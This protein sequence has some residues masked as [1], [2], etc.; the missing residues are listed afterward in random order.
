MKYGF[1]PGCAYATAAGYRPSVEAVCRRLEIE[2]TPIPDWN[3]CGATVLFSVDEFKATALAGR[4]FALARQHG[5][6]QIVTGC[7]A[8]YTTLRKAGDLLL[9]NT[10]YRQ[11]VEQRL[12]A[13]SLTDPQPLP[14][15]HLL[16]VLLDDIPAGTWQQVTASHPCQD[17][18]VGGYYGC[19]MT[20]P[21]EP[22]AQAEQPDLLERFLTRIGFKPMDHAAKTLCCG[23][24]HCVPYGNACNP[25]VTRIVRGIHRQGANL[26]AT[27]C[28]LCQFNLDQGQHRTRDLPRLP[29]L[30][31]TQLAGLAMGLPPD[32]LGLDRLLTPAQGALN[33]Q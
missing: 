5:F 10:D 32:T 14:V 19:Q 16:Q 25:L 30:F 3:C 15:R 4:T 33:N 23:A 1:Y 27:I 7:N 12:A 29:V 11:E 26:I 9:Q 21:W 13:E 28:P 31:F 18:P 20:R 22:M 24:S 6:T 8:C 2:L 17:L